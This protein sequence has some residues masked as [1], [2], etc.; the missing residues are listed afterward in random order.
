MTFMIAS[1]LL[2]GA[3]DV[4]Q[5]ASETRGLALDVIAPLTR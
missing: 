3:F 4:R 5:I 2:I 1:L